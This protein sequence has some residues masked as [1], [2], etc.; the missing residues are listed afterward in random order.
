[1]VMSKKHRVAVS[2]AMAALSMSGLH[3]GGTLNLRNP[4]LG[5]CE[6]Q[7]GTECLIKTVQLPLTQFSSINI[8]SLA[9]DRVKSACWYL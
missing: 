8:L 1:M 9:L 5:C 3:E 7:P 6:D 4:S 2:G